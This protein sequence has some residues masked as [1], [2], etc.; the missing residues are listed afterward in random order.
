MGTISF[1]LTA[2]EAKAVEAL[3]RM[4]EQ[5][6]KLL[7]AAQ[8][9]GRAGKQAGDDMAGSMDKAAQGALGL[10]GA[11]TGVASVT[12]AVIAGVGLLKKEY[13]D[14]IER[15]KEAAKTQNDLAAGRAGMISA[16]L[17]SGVNAV[18][19]DKMIAA[20]SA[21]YQ[22]PGGALQQQ[23]PGILQ[24]GG[25]VTPAQLDEAVQM[26]ARMSGAGLGATAGGAVGQGLRLQAAMGGGTLEEAM[27]FARIAGQQMGISGLPEQ[28]AALS[29]LAVVGR[30]SGWGVQGATQLA[31]YLAREGVSGERAT[32]SAARLIEGLADKG[33]ILPHRVGRGTEFLGLKTTGAAQI[34]ELQAW[35]KGASAEDRDKVMGKL[36]DRAPEAKA[37]IRGLLEGRPEDVS[38]FAAAGAAIP[39]AG[40]GTAGMEQ[41]FNDIAGGEQEPVARVGRAGEATAE[42]LRA[43]D[44]E[45]MIAQLVDQYDKYLAARG[46]G[47]TFR[48]MGRTELRETLRGTAQQQNEEPPPS[49]EVILERARKFMEGHLGAGGPAKFGIQRD[50]NGG[51]P[52]DLRGPL[53][54]ALK[55]AASPTGPG[56][57]QLDYGTG[58][59]VKVE[60][61]KDNTLNPYTPAPFDAGA[62]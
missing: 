7:E 8:A 17:P 39:G 28:E 20:A 33:G 57:Q 9:T 27:G 37:A 55:A 23:I 25:R 16:G 10:V 38:A 47:A 15:K 4:D 41:M 59:P 40:A 29:G 34:G 60:I 45:A 6:R 11:L 36:S 50:D 52:G 1:V 24:Q 44:P 54:D 22:V 51:Q 49:R 58:K 12:G 3:R 56:F 14:L 5:Q 53:G 61:D 26:A 13:D 32:Q 35:W 48:W 18:D 42:N 31:A 19:L 30:E 43:V 46:T 2:D 21:R 62:P